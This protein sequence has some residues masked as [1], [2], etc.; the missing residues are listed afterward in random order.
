MVH[1]GDIARYRSQNRQAETFYKYALVLSSRSGQPYNQLALLEASRGDKVSEVFHYVRAV[2]LPHPFPAAATNLSIALDKHLDDACVS[3]KSDNPKTNLWFFRVKIE[4]HGKLS[5]HEY[6]AAFLKLHGVLHSHA[7]LDKAEKLVQT[8][9]TSL[10]AHIATESLSSWKLI[11][12][13]FF[14]KKCPFKFF[15]CL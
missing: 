8:L 13:N 1:L 10:T 14:H 15:V 2:A 9:I 4:G 3:F 11:Q 6:L 12:V 7:E 5:H